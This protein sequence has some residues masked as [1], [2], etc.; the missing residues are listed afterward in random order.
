MLS[1]LSRSGI[2]GVLNMLGVGG[3]VLNMFGVW[4]CAEHVRGLG[5]Y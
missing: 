4:G 2:G 1:G 3:D 5:R